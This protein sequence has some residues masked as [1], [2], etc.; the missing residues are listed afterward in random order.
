MG[1]QFFCIAGG[2]GLRNWRF[3]YW[4]CTPPRKIRAQFQGCKH[5]WLIFS[6]VML[7]ELRLYGVLRSSHSPNSQKFSI[8]P[9]RYLE[10]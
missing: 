7:Y 6:V 3:Y 4:V 1:L 8:A 10:H 2:V 9:S 5:T